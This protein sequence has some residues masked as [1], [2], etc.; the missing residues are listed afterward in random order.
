MYNEK[1][2]GIYTRAGM[3]SIISGLHEGYSMASLMVEEK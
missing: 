3:R 2:K 1:F